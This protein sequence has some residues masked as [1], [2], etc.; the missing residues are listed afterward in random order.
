LDRA[1]FSACDATTTFTRLRRGRHTLLVRAVDT[2]F[3]DPTPARFV[4][5]VR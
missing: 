5:R 2:G 4:W 3:V 1:A